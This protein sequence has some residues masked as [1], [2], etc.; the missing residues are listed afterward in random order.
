MN[1]CSKCGNEPQLEVNSNNIA[2][3]QCQGCKRVDY[4]TTWNTSNPLPEV[5]EVAE[6]ADKL[7][8]CY[9]F[10][11]DI[12]PTMQLADIRIWAKHL[13]AKHRGN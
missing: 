3:M 10:L 13:L 1:P 11:E 9:A 4:Y 7:A 2:F 6:L 8:E 12:V 5:D